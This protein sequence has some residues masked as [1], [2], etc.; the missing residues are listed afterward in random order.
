MPMA[1]LYPF[2][3]DF[4]KQMGFGLGP[5]NHQ[6]AFAPDTLLPRGEK[7][8]V[9]AL[10][11]EDKGA[12]AVCYGRLQR[13]THGLM[14]KSETDM[15]RMLGAADARIVGVERD[16]RLVG[17]LSFGFDTDPGGNFIRNN[18][19]VREMAYET[20]EALAD[21]SAFLR[22]QADQIA[23][24]VIETQDEAFHHLLRDPR[25]DSGRMIPHVSHQTNIS[26]LGLMYRVLD[27][28]ALLAALA[29]ADF[30]GQTLR[31]Q[32]TVRDSFVPENAGDLVVHFAEGRPRVVDSEAGHDVALALDVAELSSLLMGVVGVERLHTYGQA[33]VSDIGYLTMLGRLF[34]VPRP[35]M[36]LTQF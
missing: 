3:I 21:L 36:C 10:G 11:P 9:R 7:A 18:L 25:D 12:L 1:A 22:A 4:Y 5:K 23:R 24:I 13:R 29:D 32:L 19:R 17:Y 6:Y 27:T 14:E 30:G 15:E 28:R 8:N 26:A 31:V 20:P 33:E 34:A 2:R 16:G 35:P